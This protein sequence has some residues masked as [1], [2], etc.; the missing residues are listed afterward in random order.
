MLYCRYER[1]RKA[2]VAKYEIKPIA[3]VKL[4]NGQTKKSCTGD[5]LSGSYYCFSYKLRDSDNELNTFLCGEHA[6]NHFLSLINHPALPLFDPTNSK[7]IRTGKEKIN[8]HS[9]NKDKSDNWD[10]AAKQ[11]HNAI[12]LII[13]CWDVVPVKALLNIKIKIERYKHKAPFPSEVKAINTI[14]S[15]DIRKR[16]IKQMILDLERQ[17]NEIRSFEFN[18]LNDILKKEYDDRSYFE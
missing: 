2:L 8:V 1:I 4:L 11:L 6:A 10:P 14:L 7:S 16:T 3:H 15:R 18:L 12:N 5:A 9:T 17:G 13:I